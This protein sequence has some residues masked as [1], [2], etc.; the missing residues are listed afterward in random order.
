MGFYRDFFFF[1]FSL[2]LESVATNETPLVVSKQP[3][4]HQNRF[5]VES[6]LFLV[7]MFSKVSK[8]IFLV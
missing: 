2:L 8:M 4:V 7:P 1:V 3:C 6:F 5:N